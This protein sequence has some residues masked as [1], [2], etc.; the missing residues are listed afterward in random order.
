LIAAYTK[1]IGVILSTDFKIVETSWNGSF[2]FILG[3]LPLMYFGTNI[4]GRINGFLTF[5]LLISFFMLISVGYQNVSFDLLKN[6]NWSLSL[7]SLPLII[8][9]FGFH[10]TLPSLVDYL[11]RDKRKIQRAIIVG[12]TITLIIYLS[13]E[14]FVLGS[15]PLNGEISLTSA[16]ENDQTAVSPLSQLSGNLMVW[17]LAHIFSLAAIITSFLGVSIG[18]VDFLIDAFQLKRTFAT[19]TSLLLSLYLS[20]LLLSMTELRIFY[21]SLNYGAGV[22][23]IF[24]L[25]FLPA[26]MMYK[27][28]N[29]RYE[30]NFFGF[31]KVVVPL[32][33]VFSAAS[34]LGCLLS[35]F[36]F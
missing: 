19:K 21:L 20:A 26:F 4:I 18:L 16:W 33:F 34:V 29:K 2:L 35:F 11:E 15:I 9:S 25:I 12:S 13:W 23:G 8:S 5:V 28:K 3:F 17:N 6:Q 10:G 30:T 31:R 1:G 24:L 22:A 27:S 36:L 7:F 14:L 32:I